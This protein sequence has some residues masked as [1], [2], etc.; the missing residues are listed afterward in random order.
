MKIR[1]ITAECLLLLTA[2][3]QL[4]GQTEINPTVRNKQLEAKSAM[5]RQKP[6][7][8]P[9]DTPQFRRNKAVSKHVTAKA[10]PA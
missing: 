6:S 4:A 10:H 5:V 8:L 3:L 9:Q 2:C 1:T 7:A